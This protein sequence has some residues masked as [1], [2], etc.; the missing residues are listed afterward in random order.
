MPS[1]Q[2]L[3]KP[4]HKINSIFKR[5]QK[6]KMLFGEYSQPEFEFLAD[7]EWVWTQKIDGTNTR[8]SINIVDEQVNVIYGGRTDN[9]QMPTFLLTKLQS[10]FGTP[11]MSEKLLKT[12]YD[13][14]SFNVV[15]YGEGYGAKIQKGG[16]N[17]IP[18]GVDFVLFDILVGDTLLERKNVEDIAEKLGID[19]VPIVG[20]GTLSQAMEL[21]KDG[22]RTDIWPNADA[23]GLVLRPSCELFDRRGHRIIC[24]TKQVDWS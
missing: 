17:Y 10:I 2:Y 16:G 4:Y 18:D 15:L 9:A 21:A 24:K 20:R 5:D 6:G 12:F 3:G 22:F 7:N 13:G 1:E 11:E 8:V 23:E 14:G 19:I